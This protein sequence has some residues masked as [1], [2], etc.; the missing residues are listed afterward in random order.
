M[1][2]QSIILLGVLTIMSSLAISADKNADTG[3]IILKSSHPNEVA[4]A[5]KN[6]NIFHNT[7][8]I[9]NKVY[10]DIAPVNKFET[11][12]DGSLV[13][14]LEKKIEQKI[15]ELLR[16]LTPW[17]S[18]QGEEGYNHPAASHL[19][20]EYKWYIDP[21]DGTISFKNGLET[22]GLTLTL[23]KKYQP[24]ATLV[25]FPKQQKIF[26]AY[27]G[28][29]AYCNGKE[30][31]ISQEQPGSHSILARSDDYAF[32]YLDR[33][34]FISVANNLEMV[35]RTY[36]DIYAYTMVLQNQC[37]AKVDAAAALWDLFPSFL[38]IREAGGDV[39]FYPA[40]DPTDD[41]YGSLISGNSSVVHKFDK[42]LSQYFDSNKPKFL[43]YIPS[44][45]ELK[46][47]LSMDS[48]SSKTQKH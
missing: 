7:I 9:F 26:T 11:K 13:S 43:N 16:K 40:A 24:I 47:G 18:F 27:A 46:N 8:Q 48:L 36:T 33:R 29:G 34:N 31:K 35:V 41:L 38:L 2:I 23:V 6:S 45:E 19:E 37:F 5:I 10:E 17:A 15:G 20:S 42:H 30:L 44:I 12:I 14:Y 32:D 25:Y 28:E 22:F 1:K 39:M 21:I 3:S 4:I